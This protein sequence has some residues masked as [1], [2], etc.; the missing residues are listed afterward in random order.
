MHKQVRDAKKGKGAKRIKGPICRLNEI[1]RV[2]KLASIGKRVV[3]RCRARPGLE[4]WS[5]GEV[6]TFIRGKLRRLTAGDYAWSEMMDFA[7]GDVE[8]DIYGSMD[9][10]GG[11]FIK[12]FMEHGQIQVCS[13]H[14]PD[15]TFVTTG[16]QTVEGKK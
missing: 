7:Q 11:W 15:E 4:N 3:D 9:K 16:G 1:T 10:H 14:W 8:V 12:L 5:D 2:A 13:C 6:E